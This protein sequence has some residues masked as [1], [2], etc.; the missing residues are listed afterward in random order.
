MTVARSQITL[1]GDDAGMFEDV[2][3]EMAEERG[4]YEPGNA[5][6]VRILIAESDYLE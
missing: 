4:G 6:A 5:E 3:E 1:C 2:K